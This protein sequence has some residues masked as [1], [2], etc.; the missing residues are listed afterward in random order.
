MNRGRKWFSEKLR[1]IL[2][3]N[4]F[5]PSHSRYVPPAVS[6]APASE[7]ELQGGGLPGLL[8]SHYRGKPRIQNCVSR[9]RCGLRKIGKIFSANNE[10][11]S[12][13]M[14]RGKKWFS[15]KL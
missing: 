8:R 3:Y 14:N 2:T 5:G 11:G 7:L 9:G 15:V 10:Q 13:S 1:N 12:K 4:I 6:R